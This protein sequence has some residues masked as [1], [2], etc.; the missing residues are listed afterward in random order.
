MAIERCT[1]GIGGIHAASCGN[2][3][4]ALEP[5]RQVL[6]ACFGEIEQGVAAGLGLHHGRGTQYMSRAFQAHFDFV[7]IESTPSFVR[8]SGG[9]GIAERFMRNLKEQLLWIRNSRTVDQLHL[10]LLDFQRTYNESWRLARDG[11]RTPNQ[12]R[13]AIVAAG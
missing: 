10:A 3:Y 1:G 4:E 7:G 2:R 11:C 8:Q 12:A 5:I 13:A 6:R 9:N